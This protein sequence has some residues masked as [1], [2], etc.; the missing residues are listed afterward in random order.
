[1]EQLTPSNK[2]RIPTLG[3]IA[4]AGISIALIATF[5]FNVQPRVV[6]KYGFFAAMILSHF[7][8]H[9]GHGKQNDNQYQITPSNSPNKLS[10]AHVENIDP[11]NRR[12]G[13]H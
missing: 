6:I 12:H 3:L 11:Q 2:F 8:M 4:I 13:C 9:S 1:M 10:A 5:I 7:W